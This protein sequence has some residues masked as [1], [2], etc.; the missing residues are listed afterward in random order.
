MNISSQFYRVTS[1]VTPESRGCVLE[2][3]APTRTSEP[4]ENPT[5]IT[6]AADVLQRCSG[7]SRT[8]NVR[9]SWGEFNG[10][11]NAYECY[12]NER[13]RKMAKL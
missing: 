6:A 5:S 8:P 1:V 13:S 12:V 2:N 7:S 11:T 10:G 9:H 4:C 3:Q